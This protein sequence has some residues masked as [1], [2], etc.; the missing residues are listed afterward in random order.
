MERYLKIKEFSHLAGVSVRT[1]QY[2]DEIGLLHPARKNEHG[3][4]MYDSSSFSQ[5]FMITSLKKMGMTLEEIKEVLT[6]EQSLATFIYQEKRRVEAELMELQL[7][8]M[9]L[10]RIESHLEAGREVSPELLL[11]LGEEEISEELLAKIQAEPLQPFDLNETQTFFKELELCYEQQLPADDPL[12]EK[13]MKY[14]QQMSLD[15][16]SSAELTAFAEKYYAKYPDQA[17]GMKKE[18]YQYLKQKIKESDQDP[19]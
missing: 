1:L 16:E 12:V 15:H 4:R 2:Y 19:S 9:K 8:L 18:W 14:W 17:L 11:L 13:C 3:H 7:R 10:S 5:L 6:K